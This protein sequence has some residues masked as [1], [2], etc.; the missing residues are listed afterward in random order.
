M[1]H[2]DDISAIYL[3]GVC[4]TCWF[5]FGAPS[6]LEPHLFKDG[7]VDRVEY[8]SLESSCPGPELGLLRGVGGVAGWPSE[9]EW[10]EVGG[11][12]LALFDL[13]QINLYTGCP[14]KNATPIFLLSPLINKLNR[15]AQLSS[16]QDDETEHSK[17][18]GVL[19]D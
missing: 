14:N 9:F 19:N 2:S 6:W 7:P 1:V 12:S 8:L 16:A 5:F 17:Q 11:I 13:K 15:D 4:I 10:M 18:I 3:L